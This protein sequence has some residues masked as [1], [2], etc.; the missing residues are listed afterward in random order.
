MCFKDSSDNT[1]YAS[2][3]RSAATFFASFAGPSNGVRAA[4]ADATLARRSR[5]CQP[6][7]SAG[8]TWSKMGRFE[9]SVVCLKGANCVAD[10]Q[11]RGVGQMGPKSKVCR[12]RYPRELLRP[13]LTTQELQEAHAALQR[14]VRSCGADGAGPIAVAL[15]QADSEARA[16]LQQRRP[17]FPRPAPIS[18]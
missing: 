12:P 2:R 16:A 6:S 15:S 14:C 7:S 5:G 13:R 3:E 8:G 9:A 17:A 1:S 10:P 11:K 4:R 18:T